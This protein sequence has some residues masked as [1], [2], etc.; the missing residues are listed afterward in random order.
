[1]TLGL[2]SKHIEALFQPLFK[3]VYLRLERVTKEVLPNMDD[4][5]I[6]GS[7]CF[8]IGIVSILYNSIGL[9]MFFYLLCFIKW[10]EFSRVH[11]YYGKIDCRSSCFVLDAIF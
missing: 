7:I 5:I 6:S 1:M 9:D 4:S 3:A 11:L 8:D 10:L 2:I